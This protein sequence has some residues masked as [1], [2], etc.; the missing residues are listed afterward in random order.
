MSKQRWWCHASRHNNGLNI[1]T[2]PTTF[3]VYITRTTT[4]TDYIT[5]QLLHKI[6]ISNSATSGHQ[7]GKLHE[8]KALSYG[9]EN[10]KKNPTNQEVKQQNKRNETLKQDRW[11]PKEHQ[12]VQNTRRNKGRETNRPKKPI[13]MEKSFQRDWISSLKRNSN[14]SPK[15]CS[16]Q[17][18][19]QKLNKTNYGTTFYLTPA[20]ALN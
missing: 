7:P 18:W 19:F 13:I 10:V 20:P 3:R 4:V 11:T 15:R 14:K 12:T 8:N 17:N 2:K 9:K 5:A 1:W 16:G 6:I